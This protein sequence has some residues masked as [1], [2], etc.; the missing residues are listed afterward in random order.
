MS[1][2]PTSKKPVGRPSKY[3]PSFC[4]IAI[5]LGKKGY[6]REAISSEL[7]ITWQTLG[8]WAEANPDFFTALEEAKKEEMLFFEKLALD[9]MIERPGGN[10]INTALWSRSMAARFPHK[11]RE[12]NKLEVTGKNNGA[13]QV[14]VVHD[15]AEELMNEILSIRQDDNDNRENS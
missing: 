12:N 1:T 11:Y 9:H 8:N 15:F 6:S 4:Q 7:G 2:Q 13:I 14:D 3:D 5:D 10:R